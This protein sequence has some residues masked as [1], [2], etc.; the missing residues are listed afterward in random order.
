[1][2]KPKLRREFLRFGAVAAT[3]L[4][5]H[6]DLDAA[7]CAQTEDNIEGP[8]YKAGARA[9]ALAAWNGWIE[10]D[11][12]RHRDEYPLRTGSARVT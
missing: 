1:M 8:Y 3:A 6:N 2:Y 9:S 5:W 10:V 11:G 4:V 7:E 12:H